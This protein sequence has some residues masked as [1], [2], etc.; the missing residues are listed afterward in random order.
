TLFFCSDLCEVGN[1]EIKPVG[2]SKSCVDVARARVL[3]TC[4]IITNRSYNFWCACLRSV[5]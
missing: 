1:G 3:E 2:T 5:L 4:C